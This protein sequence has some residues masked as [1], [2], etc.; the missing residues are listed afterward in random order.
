MV[1]FRVATW[2]PP[3]HCSTACEAR[4]WARV[5]N[6]TACVATWCAPRQDSTA[7]MATWLDPEWLC[8]VPP[9]HYSRACVASWLAP[10]SNSTAFVATWCAHR[11][12]IPRPAWLRGWLRS[13]Y[14]VCPRF[15]I[16]RSHFGSRQGVRSP[17]FFG[18][19]HAQ[20]RARLLVLGHGDGAQARSF[21]FLA[22]GRDAT[23][24]RRR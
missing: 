2:L 21:L 11:I 19:G 16:P 18:G 20:G 7:C 14:V 10:E 3:S 23:R 22:S 4:W 15:I 17:L 12:I 13:G 9:S 5:S 1:F 6:S 24:R 8:S